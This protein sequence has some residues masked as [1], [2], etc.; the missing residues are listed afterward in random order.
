MKE[1]KNDNNEDMNKGLSELMDELDEL[2]EKMDD[3]SITLEESFDMYRKGV[4][5]LKS[6]RE[7]I[8]GIEKEIQILE[9]GE[10]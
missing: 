7:K 6:C 4:M 5:K 3:P 10:E 8:E 1:I 2:I 9:E